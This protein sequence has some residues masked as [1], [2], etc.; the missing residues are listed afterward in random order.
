M[1]AGLLRQRITI[2]QK[3]LTKNDYGEPIA[4]WSDL[5]SV[6]ASISPRAGRE[7]IE[8]GGI[9]AQDQT[10]TVEMRYQKSV[11]PE[12]R[13]KFTDPRTNSVRYF[14]IEAV[15]EPFIRGMSLMLDVR[16]NV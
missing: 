12:M 2:Q 7:Y 10:Y 6:W 9:Q 4:T 14:D 13:V 16:E 8:G 15:K 11:T 5:Y 1:R 3:T